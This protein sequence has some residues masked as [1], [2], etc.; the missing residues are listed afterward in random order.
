MN[1]AATYVASGSYNNSFKVF[2][3]ADGASGTPLEATRDPMRRRLQPV[4][5][6]NRST[7]LRRRWQALSSS[8]QQQQHGP[9]GGLH[10]GHGA[11]AGCDSTALASTLATCV[12]NCAI[13]HFEWGCHWCRLLCP[14]APLLSFMA[15]GRQ[16]NALPTQHAQRAHGG[17]QTQPRRAGRGS[18]RLPVKAAALGVAPRGQRHCVCRVK[19]PLHVLRMMRPVAHCSASCPASSRAPGRVAARTRL[20]V[21]A[22]WLGMFV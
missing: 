21:R 22:C 12:L 19:Q 5:V 7:L 15:A 3:C 14:A 6:S 9:T 13:L 4:R 11:H 1:G 2:K 18:Q 17:W 10:R 16:L 8:T 20:S